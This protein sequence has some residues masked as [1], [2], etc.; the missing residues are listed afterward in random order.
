MPQV[1]LRLCWRPEDKEGGVACEGFFEEEDDKMVTGHLGETEASRAS[2]MTKK[3]FLQN[4][5]L[6]WKVSVSDILG[7]SGTLNKTS[8]FTPGRPDLRRFPAL[9]TPAF[10]DPPITV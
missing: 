8:G 5:F 10:L 4:V 1:H 9:A 2:K 3:P 7:G 6:C